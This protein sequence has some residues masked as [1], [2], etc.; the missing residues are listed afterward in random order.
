[1]PTLYEKY[2][3]R[4]LSEVMAQTRVCEMLQARIDRGALGGNAYLITGA[5][6]TGKTT[7][8]HII[9]REIADDSTFQSLT[10]STPRRRKLETSKTPGGIGAWARNPAAPGL[11][12]K[13]T[14]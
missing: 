6:G 14:P 12:T 3:P 5:S 1:M 8:A 11:S 10:Q 2:R 9:A 13:S 4:K 7:L